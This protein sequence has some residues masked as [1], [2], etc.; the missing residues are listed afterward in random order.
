MTLPNWNLLLI[1]CADIILSLTAIVL[2]AIPAI[3]IGLMIWFDDRGPFLFKQKR[4]GTAQQPFNILKFRTM[5]VDPERALGDVKA[6]NA[7]ARSLFETT[8]DNDPRITRIGKFLRKSHLDELPQF[9]NVLFGDMSIVGVRPDTPVQ[10][11]D[12][13]P[14]YWRQRSTLRPGIT[15]PAQLK[16]DTASLEERSS[17]E[18][19]W[20]ENPTLAAYIKIFFATIFKVLKR[21]G[22]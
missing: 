4:V 2:L 18:K 9:L 7:E 15:G 20:L 17:L 1:R 3:T 21:S 6:T 5:Y 14:E 8:Q 13:T 10:E 11:I 19:T 22:N 12:Y 16:S